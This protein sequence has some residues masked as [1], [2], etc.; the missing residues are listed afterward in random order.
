MRLFFLDKIIFIIGLAMGFDKTLYFCGTSHIEVY[1][2][3]NIVLSSFLSK[4]NPLQNDK[5][6]SGRSW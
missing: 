5:S 3:R 4:I 6:N 1:M 2:Y